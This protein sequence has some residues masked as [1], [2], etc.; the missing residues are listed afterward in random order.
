MG[1]RKLLILVVNLSLLISCSPQ[2]STPNLANKYT[3]NSNKLFLRVY[4]QDCKPKSMEDELFVIV[5]SPPIL[6]NSNDK[7]FLKTLNETTVLSRESS[8]IMLIGN[9]VINKDGQSCL[10]D[11]MGQFQYKLDYT[12]F[13]EIISSLEWQPANQNGTTVYFQKKFVLKASDGNFTSIEF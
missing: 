11:L 3:S 10:S 4:K 5:N 8:S 7:E 9:I 6:Q 12:Q 1:K 13:A 2:L